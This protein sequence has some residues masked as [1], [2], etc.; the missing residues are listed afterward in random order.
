M[1]QTRSQVSKKL[2]IA[3][4]GTKY[5]ARAKIDLKN[6]V[7]VLI[8]LRDMLKLARTAREVNEIIKQKLVKIN[9]REVEDC[10][11]SIRLFNILEAEK[12]YILTLNEKGKFIFESTSNTKERLC[13]VIGKKIL[14]GNKLQ[15]NL[16]DGTNI[17]T[18]ANL[19]IN[20]SIYLD[21]ENKIK[22]HVK[23]EKGKKLLIISGKYLGAK[24]TFEGI[25]DNKCIIEI[26]GKLTGLGKEAVIVL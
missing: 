14:K 11:E 15:F 2:P 26:N 12:K 7:P 25:R 10:H 8:A 18:D 4:K 5:V 6:S 13:K 24:G 19:A 17:L 3:R 22:K 9:D 20:D 23:M 21:S 16:H 1:H